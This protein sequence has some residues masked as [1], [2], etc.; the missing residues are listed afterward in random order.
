MVARPLP[1]ESARDF[2][3]WY[4]ELGF[5]PVRVPYGRKGPN[6]MGW[7]MV[8][9]TTADVDAYFS[10][11]ARSNIGLRVGEWSGNYGDVDLDVPQA[12]LV[13]SMF[14]PATRM[15]H[16]HASKRNSHWGYRF[17]EPPDSE[18]FCDVD[19]DG[20][21]LIELWTGQRRGGEESARQIIVPPSVHEDTGEPILF[22]PGCD[23]SPE[24]VEGAVLV[25]AV[26]KLAAATL[27]GRHWPGKGSHCRQSTALALAGWLLRQGI[28][29]TM[30]E[31][32]IEA[33]ATI[34]RDEEVGKRI[35][36]VA[37]TKARLDAGEECTGA[38]TLADLL[39]G[40]GSAVLD[41]VVTW[42]GIS[43]FD[44]VSSSAILPTEAEWPQLEEEALYGLAGDVVRALRPHT[45]ADP[46]A[47]LVTTLVAF[48]NAAGHSAYAV[49]EGSR[50]TLNLYAVIV[51]PTSKGRKGTSQSRI[52]E[53]FARV[54]PDWEKR[55][56][57][58]GGLSSGEGLIHQVRDPSEQVDDDGNPKDPGVEDKRLL[59]VEE[60]FASVLKTMTREGNVL[61][62]IIRQAWDRGDLR[63]LTR[64]SPAHAT[65]AHIS[66]IG[67]ITRGELLKYLTETEYGSG[68]ANRFLWICAK[69]W[70]LLPDG[71]GTPDYRTIVPRLRAA[72]DFARECLQPL[73]RDDAA[74]ALW[75]AEY[76]KLSDERDGL[77]GAVTARAEAQV[78]R[79][80]TLYAVLA[81]SSVVRVE[82]LRAALALWR[83]GDASTAYIFGGL[84]GDG[85]ADRI[86]E[87]MRERGTTGLSKTEISGLFGRNLPA[88]RIDAGLRSLEL[89]NRIVRGTV[90][91][92]GRPREVYVAR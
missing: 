86:L 23:A 64:N 60:E 89:A 48:G 19:E 74:R 85:V 43:R 71:G 61:S 57:L 81:C 87:A 32:I 80:S 91:T 75:H 90:N 58:S 10:A 18:Q 42:L 15:R 79:L 40:N 45:E 55:R 17:P 53:L 47:L 65:D 11:G 21:K 20:T 25:D 70:Q 73:E 88:T 22:E 31:T 9:I 6:K 29:P 5:A 7:Q 62:A 83:Y 77:L 37:D 46:A 50:H 49:A 3:H 8:R 63:I 24:L 82:H 38:P 84:Q 27:I 12:A 52:R 35:E 41:R 54:D 69:R 92:G 4:C 33:A 66:L 51:A 1:A 14:L 30:V 68:F 34:G 67:H 13:A 26:H 59:V 28:H 78:L 76:P 16:G 39:T 44:A 56:M 2:A 36:C 72:L